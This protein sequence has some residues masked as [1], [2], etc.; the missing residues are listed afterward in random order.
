MKSFLTLREKLG[1]Q[2]SYLSKR[3]EKQLI[4]VEAKIRQRTVMI[5]LSKPP[6]ISLIQTHNIQHQNFHKIFTKVSFL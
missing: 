4:G 1:I 6:V 2:W 5:I 3:K